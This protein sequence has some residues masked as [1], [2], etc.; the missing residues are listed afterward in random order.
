MVNYLIIILFYNG[1][2]LMDGLYT[3][4]YNW[5]VQIFLN[6]WKFDDFEKREKKKNYIRKENKLFLL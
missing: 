6:L 2:T 5:A 3:F 4:S 1:I